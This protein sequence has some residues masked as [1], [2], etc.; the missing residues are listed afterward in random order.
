MLVVGVLSYVQD[1]ATHIT[2]SLCDVQPTTEPSRMNRTK[3]G[4][5]SQAVARYRKD[6]EDK[7]YHI[8]TV[9]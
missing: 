6:I 3:M 1:G 4:Q 2:C 5:L 7:T 9:F 8:E